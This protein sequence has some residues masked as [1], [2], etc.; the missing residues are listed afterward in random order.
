MLLLDKK[1][2]KGFGF[3]FQPGLSGIQM[4]I[5][6]RGSLREENCSHR[7]GYCSSSN[8]YGATV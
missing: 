8:M 6:L 5:E 2:Q 3:F 7:G 4:G 1:L